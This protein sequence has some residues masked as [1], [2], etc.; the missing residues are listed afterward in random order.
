M[1]R[2]FTIGLVLLASLLR[3]DGAT[4]LFRLELPEGHVTLPIQEV[5]GRDYFPVQVL[6][7]AVGVAVESQGGRVL[8]LRLPRTRMR[9]TDGS[10]RVETENRVVILSGR[11]NRSRGRFL[12][13]TDLVP[14]VL[15]E[16]FGE[17]RVFWDPLRRE[18]KVS[19]RDFTLRLL[20]SRSYADFT[21][22]V[23]VE[24][25]PLE[26]TLFTEDPRQIVLVIP[27]GVLSPAI[28][29]QAIDDGLV[30]LVEPVQDRQG[31]RFV[32]RTSGARGT[33]K[34]F[35]LTDPDRIVLDVFR[36]QVAGRTPA[37]R[38]P[39]PRPQPTT[40]PAPLTVVLDPG[41]GGRDTGAVGPRGLREK[42]VVLDIAW[43]LRRLLEERLGVRVV[44]T[45]SEDVFVPL[46]ERA[47]I[48]NRAKGDFFVSIHV[49]A[50]PQSRA[51]GFE[52]YYLS[53]EPSDSD[54]RASVLREN[55]VLNL[56]EGLSAREQD[57]LKETLWDITQTLN[58]NESAELAELLL[59][60]LDRILKVENRGVK[61]GPF[62]VLM[63]AAM[64]AVLVETA[65]ITNPHEERKLQDD[66][67]KQRVA[68]ALLAGIAKFKARYEKRL[69]MVGGRPP[70]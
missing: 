17:D 46:E 38:P 64:P 4:P 14:L 7:R 59:D 67:F 18:A 51:V 11:T 22:I 6:A 34:V 48:A 60:D 12:A 32:I 37:A 42:D 41:H 57:H 27:Q 26:Y 49:N 52:T 56:Y 31:A 68:E 45:R 53:K 66:R 30:Q 19:E 24:T 69:G 63:R 55:L 50:A 5:A 9:L 65:F 21:R 54:A 47:A 39:G 25:R 61:H 10:A 23:L 35:T 16:R 58:L 1:G 43:R 36:A 28:R 33:P 62:F 13:P 15:S 40:A 29:R 3:A 2:L 44:L 70:G 8:V 20:R